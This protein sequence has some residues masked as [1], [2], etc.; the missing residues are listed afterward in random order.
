M[1][2]TYGDHRMAMALAPVSIYIPGI[3]VRDTGVASKSYPEFWDDLRMAGFEV[4]DA[5]SADGSAPQSSE[6]PSGDES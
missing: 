2:D 1:F 6:E 4:T 5:D 3:V